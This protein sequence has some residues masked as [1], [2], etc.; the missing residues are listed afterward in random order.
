MQRAAAKRGDEHAP[1]QFRGEDLEEGAVGC[2]VW[3]GGRRRWVMVFVAW[4]AGM[5]SHLVW[6]VGL[7]EGGSTGEGGEENSRG[8]AL[9]KVVSASPWLTQLA[10]IG[11]AM[12]AG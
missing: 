5:G 11:G 4:R 3:F 9:E 8:W 1:P 7:G 10:R 6:L 12:H 2:A